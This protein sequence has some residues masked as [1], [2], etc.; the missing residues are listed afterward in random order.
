MLNVNAYKLVPRCACRGT[1]ILVMKKGNKLA[2]LETGLFANVRAGPACMRSSCL[3]KT[4][5]T[6]TTAPYKQKP[7]RTNR[8]RTREIYDLSSRQE[9]SSILDA[10]TCVLVR[11]ASNGNLFVVI[12]SAMQLIIDWIKLFL[13]G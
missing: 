11:H 6:E 1:F 3:A 7:L 8:S 12:S 10:A 4:E 2:A 13:H 5:I 9:M